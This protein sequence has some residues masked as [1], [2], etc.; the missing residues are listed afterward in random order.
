[1]EKFPGMIKLFL[2]IVFIIANLYMVCGN[3]NGFLVK[4]DAACKIWWTGNTCKIMKNDPAPV[5]KRGIL[6]QAARNEAEGFQI[7]LSPHSV[8][9]DISVS[10][11]DFRQKCGKIIPA[12]AVTIRKVEYVNIT[13][14]SGRFHTGGW[15][16]DPLPQLEGSFTAEAGINSPLWFT[17]KIPGEAVPGLYTATVTIKSAGWET[18]IPVRLEVWDFALPDIPYMRSAFGLYSGLIR[19]YHHLDNNTEL[20][21]V[22]DKYYASFKEH[23]ISPMQMN[24]LHPIRKNVKGIWW[25]GGTFDPDTV[26]QGRYS[27]QVNDNNTG[28]NSSAQYKDL[29]KIDPS[30][31][32][33]LKWRVKTLDKKQKYSVTVRCYKSD[34]SLIP[35]QLKGM[36]FD[37]STGWKEDSLYIDPEDPATIDDMV[38]FRPFPKEAAFASVHLY[39]VI[40]DKQGGKTGVAWFDDFRFI[41]MNDHINLLPEGNFEQNIDDLNVE[42]DFSDFDAGAKK[43]LDS[44]GFTGFR[45]SPPELSD[46]PFWGRKVGWFEGFINGTPEYKKLITLYLKGFQDHLETNGWLGKEYLYWIDEPR[47]EDYEFVRE[48]MR[49]IHEAAPGLTRFITENDPGPEIMDV[50]EIGCPVLAKFDPEKSKEW[51][52][53]GRKMW[54]YLMTWPKSPHVNLFIDSDAINMRIWLW[55]SYQYRLSGILVWNTDCWNTK[56]STYPG[57]LQNYWEDP[58]SYNI[59]MELPVGVAAEFGNGDGVLF[60]PP[61]RDPNQDKSKYLDGP[62]PSLRL[63]ILREGLEDY[64]YMMMLEEKI[65]HAKPEQRKLVIE[66]RQTLS[67]TTEIFQS[68]TSYTKD[69][70][71]L[72]KRRKEIAR[73]ISM[74]NK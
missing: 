7:V 30:N 16:P 23:R 73:L 20:N 2:P 67:F 14:P 68:E 10:V 8:L 41:E 71:I 31:P 29:I 70:D 74:F 40:P 17:I 27:Y 21:Q 38:I 50:T 39:P 22:L 13:K 9:K 19:E 4:A 24:D 51:I 12:K 44:M 43:Y 61:N 47:Q 72:M 62:V 5:T 15:Y 69:P 34:R 37:G 49:T 6:I 54:T 46:G 11:T 36:I 26:F 55:M 18:A 45:F 25:N 48:G 42:L 65:K 56:E 32:Y 28:N 63:E 64:D 52:S 60:Y 33:L 35:W 53:K 57:E 66:A 59:A 1:M 3:N 58:M